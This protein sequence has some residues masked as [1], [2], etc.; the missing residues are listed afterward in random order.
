MPGPMRN[1]RKYRSRYASA[2][3]VYLPEG[4]R[5]GRAPK[6]PAGRVWSADE[7]A[8]WAELW[9]SPQSTQWN[10]GTMPTVA[11]YTSLMVAMLSGQASAWR[12]TEVRHLADRLGLTP[13]GLTALGW[14]I[15]DDETYELHT[16]VADEAPT[17]PKGGQPVTDIRSR[18]RAIG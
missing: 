17:P 10:A 6:L 11:L 13:V 7:K 5:K 14:Q 2:K 9:H 15:T 4:G 16:A 8:L 1:P 12:S 3:V 18:I